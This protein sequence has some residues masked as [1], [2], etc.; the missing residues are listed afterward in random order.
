[1]DKKAKIQLDKFQFNA[2]PDESRSGGFCQLFRGSCPDG[3]P[4]VAKVLKSRLTWRVEAKSFAKEASIANRLQELSTKLFPIKAIAELQYFTP[5]VRDPGHPWFKLPVLIWEDIA[6]PTL[7]EWMSVNRP[8]LVEAVFITKQ[9]AQILAAAHELGFAHR[10][11]KPSNVIMLNGELSPVIIDWGIGAFTGDSA[12]WRYLEPPT[13]TL[14]Y[15]SPEQMCNE[16]GAVPYRS[17]CYSLGII[18]YQ[19]L[20]GVHPFADRLG[21]SQEMHAGVFKGRQ[22]EGIKLDEWERLISATI[23]RRTAVTE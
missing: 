21:W 5:E 13:G 23:T 17:D 18:F 22:P 4:I 6:G 9:I 1:M 7:S 10:D 20:T 8:T 15:M 16:D 11:V 12:V 2:E 3:K 14:L 19:L